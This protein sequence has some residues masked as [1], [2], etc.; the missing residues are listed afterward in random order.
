MHRDAPAA[1]ER[2]RVQTGVILFLVMGCSG[3]GNYRAHIVWLRDR[4]GILA[5]ILTSSSESKL[6]V[7]TGCCCFGVLGMCGVFPGLCFHLLL[8]HLNDTDNSH[9]RA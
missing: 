5:E 9:T 1:M 6:L 2:E 4:D 8:P 3:R 7:I